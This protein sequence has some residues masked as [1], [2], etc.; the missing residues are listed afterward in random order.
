ML[1]NHQTNSYEQ[2]HG[3]QIERI[4]EFVGN[5]AFEL[6]LMMHIYW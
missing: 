6:N 4:Q 5:I 2:N 1:F 3:Q